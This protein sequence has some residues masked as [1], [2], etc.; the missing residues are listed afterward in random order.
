MTGSSRRPIQLSIAQDCASGL[1]ISR[2]PGY[3][4]SITVRGTLIMVLPDPPNGHNW[5]IHKRPLPWAGGA[6]PDHGGSPTILQCPPSELWL[7]R[8]SN[9]RTT[10]TNSRI[11]YKKNE[12]E[13]NATCLIWQDLEMTYDYMN[14][15]SM[16]VKHTGAARQTKKITNVNLCSKNLICT[17]K[18]K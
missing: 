2:R 5:I 8:W 17:T 12:L 18:W 4:R 16:F 11:M 6:Q 3:V 13:K 7:T 14:I 10:N 9:P 15:S 1:I